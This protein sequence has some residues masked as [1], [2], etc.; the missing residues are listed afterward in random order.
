ML[1]INHFLNQVNCK[2]F[3]REHLRVK[4]CRYYMILHWENPNWFQIFFNQWKSKI[5]WKIHCFWLNLTLFS[6]IHSMLY[7]LTDTCRSN[8][9]FFGGL[10]FPWHHVYRCCW[11]WS[12]LCCSRCSYRKSWQCSSDWGTVL[13]W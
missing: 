13:L 4:L 3:S 7:T 5:K 9:I 1:M 8:W 12:K 10:L 11:W 2:N 6:L